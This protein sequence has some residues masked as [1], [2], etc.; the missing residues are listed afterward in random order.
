MAEPINPEAE[1]VETPTPEEAQAAAQ[2]VNTIE[3]AKRWVESVFSLIPTTGSVWANW[4]GRGAEFSDRIRATLEQYPQALAGSKH[5]LITVAH[6][7]FLFV[8]VGLMKAAM[9]GVDLNELLEMIASDI[10][11]SPEK[12]AEKYPKLTAVLAQ[13]AAATQ[14]AGQGEE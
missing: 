11:Q 10:P 13:R 9:E 14:A 4:D 5:P 6:L 7:D 2:A 12:V 1:G 8:A 3:G